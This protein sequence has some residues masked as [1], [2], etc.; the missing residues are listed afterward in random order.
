MLV[1]A[2]VQV[3]LCYSDAARRVLAEECGIVLGEDPSVLLPDSCD[4]KLVVLESNDNIGA[5]AASGTALGGGALILPCSLSTLAKVSSGSASN[6]IERVCQVAL[7]EAKPLLIVPRETPLSRIHLDC[8]SRLAWAGA[9]I[10]PASPGFYHNPRSIEELVDH[11]CA[12]ILGV[13]DIPQTKIAPWAGS[14]KTT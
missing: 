4:S 11:L 3:S 9:T 7:K 8:M 13:L 6:L 12:K 10:L 14:R 1:E 5:P 2:D